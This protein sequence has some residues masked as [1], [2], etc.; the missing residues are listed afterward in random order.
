VKNGH[1]VALLNG[2]KKVEQMGMEPVRKA[3]QCPPGQEG[4]SIGENL[5]LA[6]GCGSRL[7]ELRV[8]GLRES[9]FQL[10][11]DCPCSCVVHLPSG[12]DGHLNLAS[13]DKL[14]DQ[15]PY[16]K[17]LA[18]GSAWARDS[19]NPRVNM[20]LGQL[21]S[22]ICSSPVFALATVQ[23]VCGPGW[24]RAGIWLPVGLRVSEKMGHKV[25]L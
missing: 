23:G 16:R 4:A 9:H 2:K 7:A 17:S 18:M 8:T 6:L 14:D 24:N 13:L 21:G 15:T 11:Q 3:E 10:S 25:F 5:A 22:W 19:V 20:A 12:V 1:Q